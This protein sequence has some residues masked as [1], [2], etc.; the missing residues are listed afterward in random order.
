V[1]AQRLAVGHQEFVLDLVAEDA[2]AAR[3]AREASAK[4][5]QN[6]LGGFTG[7]PSAVDLPDDAFSQL[8]VVHETPPRKMRRPVRRA[9]R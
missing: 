6:P 2:P 8:G 1:H 7:Q 5:V 4:S 3:I 9:V